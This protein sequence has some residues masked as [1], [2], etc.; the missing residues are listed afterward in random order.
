MTGKTLS[1]N[2]VTPNGLI[3]R[4]SGKDMGQNGHAC[5][6]ETAKQLPSVRNGR[7]SGETSSPVLE[8]TSSTKVIVLASCMCVNFLCIGFALGL[9]VVFVQILDVFNTTRAQTSLMQSLC[10]GVIFS[11]ALICGPIVQKLRPGNAMI[12][13]G[14]LSM[15]GCVG[16]SFAP[17]VD[18]L[19]VTVGFITGFGMCFAHLSSFIATGRVLVKK[20]GLGVSLITAGAGLGAFVFPQYNRLVLGVYGWRGTFL[21]QAGVNFNFCVLGLLIRCLTKP[22][23]NMKTLEEDPNTQSFVKSLNLHLFKNV[24]YMIFLLCQPVIWCFYTGVV[25]F[26]VDVAKTRGYD[27]EA[28]SFLLSAMTVAHVGGSLLGGMLDTVFHFPPLF[29]CSASLVI[30]GALSLCFVFFT[31][32]GV[33]I[34]LAIGH[35]VMLAVVD[36]SIPIALIKMTTPETYSSA[37]SYMFGLSG[38]SDIASGPISGAIRDVTGDYLLMFYLATGVAVVM[39]TVFLSLELWTRRRKTSYMEETISEETIDTKL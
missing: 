36:V 28:S 31:S 24:P 11:G 1:T 15:V 4:Q 18:V 2:T 7:P 3:T 37:L 33:M 5:S 26:I 19:I 20:K 25:V 17:N 21:L 39:G 35:G 16:A 30:S 32:Y 34:T 13:G 8:L 38:L 6:G 23:Y 29:S 10:I 12:L 14:F 27:L 22:I 9:G